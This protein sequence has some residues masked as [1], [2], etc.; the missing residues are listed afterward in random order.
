MAKGIS[1]V[2]KV[3]KIQQ[4]NANCT[5]TIIEGNYTTGMTSYYHGLAPGK[6]L[7]TAVLFKYFTHQ[8]FANLTQRGI[9]LL[10]KFMYQL[11]KT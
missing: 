4:L 5:L 9:T 7:H 3:N 11:N 2:N 10:L 1:I 8:H 6:S